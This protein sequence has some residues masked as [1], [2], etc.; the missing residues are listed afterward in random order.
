MLICP[1]AYKSKAARWPRADRTGSKLDWGSRSILEKHLV[2]L[3]DEATR[4]CRQRVCVPSDAMSIDSALRACLTWGSTNTV[5]G[6]I[7]NSLSM[8]Q[9]NSAK[10]RVV[11][12]DLRIG[13]GSPSYTG[14]FPVAAT[15]V[16]WDVFTNRRPGILKALEC[17]GLHIMALPGARIPRGMSLPGLQDVGILAR[18]GPDYASTAFVWRK[19]VLTNTVSEVDDLGS[20]RRLPICMSC[21]SEGTLWMM[22]IYLPPFQGSSREAEWH[23]EVV[24]LQQDIDNMKSVW[25][26]VPSSASF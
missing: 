24:G 9:H 21:G 22:C 25:R 20:A 14:I 13:L 17:R 19:S 11:L 8:L 16:R 7:E 12:N 2:E 23:S 18:S 10:E 3:R 6:K 1:Y 4:L 15:H 5:F 26:M